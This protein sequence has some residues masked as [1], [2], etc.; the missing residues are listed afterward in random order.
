MLKEQLL[1][2]AQEIEVSV[3]LDGIFESVELSEEMQQNFK[4][5]FEAAVKKNAATLA[6]AHIT[7]IAEKADERVNEAVEER[8]KA[9]EAKLVECADKL[10]EHTAK[11]WLAENKVQVERGIKAD[12][13]ES[14]FEGLKALVVEHNVVLP[15]ESVDVVTEME[16]E[17]QE[18]KEEN[19]KLF[20]A[21]T[22]AQD[23][24]KTLKRE[25]AVNEATSELTESQKEK[26][27]GLIEGLE[28]GDAF[29]A[30]LQAIVEMATTTKQPATI[31]ESTSDTNE[32]EINNTNSEADGLNYIVEEHKE[33]ETSPVPNA[34]INSYVAAAKR[35]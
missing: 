33:P 17:L 23:E 29:E 34:K 16:E 13:F 22:E 14:M 11:E 26:V 32:A 8:S 21:L 24:L 1:K 35:F 12:L 3:E 25:I 4:T 28:Y 10:F 2:E 9:I 31:V 27:H 6:E 7:Q 19:S 30:K 20:S 5:V 18:H 15:E